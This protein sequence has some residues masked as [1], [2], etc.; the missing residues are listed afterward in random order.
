M[1][2]AK[3]ARKIAEERNLPRDIL[4]RAEKEITVVAEQ[5]EFEIVF[6]C[7]TIDRKIMKEVIGELKKANYQVVSVPNYNNIIIYW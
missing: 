4:K 1:I 2:T 5:G 7:G 6:D 3:E